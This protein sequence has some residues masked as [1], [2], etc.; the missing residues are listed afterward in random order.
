MRNF[1]LKAS[2]PACALLLLSGCVDNNYDLSNLKTETEI[3]VND[4]VL[5]L[6]L[7]TVT[8]GDIITIDEDSEGIKI[9]TLDGQEVYAVSEKGE[10]NSDEIEINGFTAQSRTI[11]PSR[12]VFN[13]IPTGTR[14]IEV[15][16]NYSLHSFD[17]QTFSIHA[18]G[19]DE[20]IHSIDAL[21]MQ[22][23][24]IDV[25]FS[26]VGLDNSTSIKFNS[27]VLDFLKGMSFASLPAGYSYDPQ[28]G[29]L[30][31]HNLECP[32]HKAHILLNATGIDFTA[33]G[34][35]IENH[36]FKFDGS[37]QLL[38]AEIETTLSIDPANP[39]V[40][41]SQVIFEVKTEIGQCVAKNFTGMVEYNLEGNDLNIAPVE[42]SD[43]PDFLAGDETN[44]ALANPQIYLSL[45]NPTAQYGITFQ[46]GLQLVANR[47]SGSKEFS[48]DPG[49][50]VK[51]GSNHG[52]GPYNYVLSPSA[53]ASPL[54]A[55]AQNLEHVGFKGLGM[56]LAGNGIPN[57]IDINLVNPEMPL[58]KVTKFELYNK[59][60]GIKGSYE[61]LAPLAL[62]TGENA[63]V[64]VYKETKEWDDDLSDFKIEKLSLT[65]DA[66]SNVP[67]D[68]TFTAHP[69]HKD[70]NGELVRINN[71][72]ISQAHI[73]P[74]QSG[75]KLE[76]SVVAPEGSPI[77][78]LAG[79]SIEAVVKPGSEEA[80]SPQQTIKLENIKLTISGSYTTNFDG[81]ND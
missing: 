8:L 80:L 2:V 81:D 16:Y 44:I 40:P 61:F 23:M 50:I 67:I 56:V 65:A 15:K 62:K 57:S 63:A 76:I 36:N 38:S 70:D 54:P 53:P 77:A 1:L 42:L 33:S 17:P 37:I 48:L 18:E 79:I 52:M 12:A 10:F 31:I 49:Q 58:Q 46:T 35:K 21:E 4:L 24:S 14:A 71:L 39:T 73:A 11:Q 60:P 20:S 13:L 72:T 34:T 32:G 68:A 22:P 74:S 19:I 55:F 78:N 7:E 59:L 51:I 26:A 43:L 66:F 9:V 29:R 27:L 6:N 69:M 28:T 5:P 64:I 30:E 3:K 75:Q 25:D 47:E 45:Q 41:D